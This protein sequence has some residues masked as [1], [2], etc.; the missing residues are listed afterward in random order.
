MALSRINIFHSLLAIFFVLAN[1][2]TESIFA[3]TTISPVGT[4]V[5]DGF[6]PK[7]TPIPN[8]TLPK[9]IADQ[10][11]IFAS[12][13]LS[14]PVEMVKLGAA[15]IEEWSDSCLGLGGPAESCA[16]VIVD[17]WRVTVSVES[18]DYF[19]RTNS[20][21][22][23]IRIEPQEE[24]PAEFTATDKERFIKLVSSDL[25]IAADKLRVI[26]AKEATFDG[27]FG[28]YKPRQACAQIAFIGWQVI[29]ASNK[30]A[31]VYNF[32]GERILKNTTASPTRNKLIPSFIPIENLTSLDDST[33]FQSSTSGDITGRVVR[34]V[35]TNDGI[36][37]QYTSAPNIKTKPVVIKKITPFRL[38]S[39]KRLLE[40]TRFPNL[41]GIAY[42]SDIAFADYPT[43][44]FQ[45][46]G[47]STQYIDTELQNAPRALRVL[48]KSWE[49]L[50]K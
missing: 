27:C 37:T 8:K 19:F 42:I 30:K 18:N 11:L 43:T 46:I 24:L 3:Q 23:F 35:L 50:Q 13:Q 2:F 29:V 36:I 25:M 21:G 26:E 12:Q 5:V 28:I 22:S 38:E 7:G 41:N 17:G 14:V 31:W 47:A 49:R 1:F 39:F 15:T 40:M 44:T 34:I 10:V 33:V 9:A 6:V 4:P 16:L 32:S 45:G 20:D 48:V